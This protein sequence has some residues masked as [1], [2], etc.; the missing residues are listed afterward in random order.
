MNRSP[1]TF[2]LDVNMPSTR[3]SGINR[4]LAE[5]KKKSLRSRILTALFGE[6]HDVV[7]IM[8]SRDV[9]NVT[10]IRD[11]EGTKP[12]ITAEKEVSTHEAAPER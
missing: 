5:V 3:A 7:I 4:L 1:S 11:G 10:F 12:V 6:Q 9:K 2:T 8:P